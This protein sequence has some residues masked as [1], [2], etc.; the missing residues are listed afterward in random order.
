[1]PDLKKKNDFFLVHI[2]IEAPKKRVDG[3]LSSFCQTMTRPTA[4]CC[5]LSEPF[6]YRVI[7]GKV[8]AEW[9]LTL[10]CNIIIFQ[11]PPAIYL[12]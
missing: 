3:I 10:I 9:P 2:Y 11:N 7:I 8:E 4:H 5:R 1:M 6:S 12:V